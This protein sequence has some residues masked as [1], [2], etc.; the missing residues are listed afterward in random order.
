MRLKLLKFKNFKSFKNAEIYFTSNLN[1]IL[2]PNGS[3]KSNICDGLKFILGERSL[4][5]LRVKSSKEL[6]HGDSNYANVQAVFEYNGVQLILEREIH[7]DKNVYKIN[8]KR[9]TYEEYLTE[10]IKLNLGNSYRFFIMQGQ[11][12]KIIGLNKNEKMQLLYDGAGIQQFEI[13]KNEILDE[14]KVIDER[15]SQLSLLIGEKMKFLD[16]L[17]V[18]SERASMYMDVKN[19]IEILRNTLAYLEYTRISKNIDNAKTKLQELSNAKTELEQKLEQIRA[20]I[21]QVNKEREALLDELRSKE[22]SKILID[23]T[24]QQESLQK[25]RAELMD[26]QRLLFERNK[27]YQNMLNKRQETID[28]IGW[29]R[30]KIKDV[31]VGDIQ[32]NLDKLKVVNEELIEI[33]AELSNLNVKYRE[34]GDMLKNIDITQLKSELARLNNEI[35]EVYKQDRELSDKIKAIDEEIRRLEK[36][37]ELNQIQSNILILENFIKDLKSRVDGIHDMVI[38]LIS[39]DSKL[40]NAVD[41]FGT[42]LLNI[43]VD[44]VDNAKTINEILKSSSLRLGRISIIPLKQLNVP[45]YRNV[46]VGLG[47]LKNHIRTEQRFEKVLD[48]VFGDVVLMKGFD[49][50]RNYI[51]KYRMVTLD[52][53]MF[54]LTGVITIGSSNLSISSARLYSE[55]IKKI[56]ELKTKRDGLVESREKLAHRIAELRERKAALDSKLSVLSTN[57]STEDLSKIGNRIDQLNKRKEE[58]K[59]V[60]ETLE[61]EI[62]AYQDKLKDIEQVAAFKKELEIKGKEL[63][64]IE[65][66]IR[67]LDQEIKELNVQIRSMSDQ[68]RIEELGVA[69]KRRQYMEMDQKIREKMEESKYK[70][71]ELKTLGYEQQKISE[72]L[73]N[74]EKSYYRYE[75]ELSNLE[76]ELKNISYKEDVG[77]VEGSK[78]QIEQEVSQLE[79]TI[80]SFGNINFKAKEMY[81]ALSKDIGEIDQ[82]IERLRKE[83]ED[84]VNML[85]EVEAKKILFFKDFIKR[86]DD[87]FK[88]LTRSIAGLGEATIELVEGNIEISLF[89][90]NKKIRLESLSGGEKS[91]L[92]LLLIFAMNHENPLPITVFDEVDA[93]LDKMNKERLKNFILSNSEKTQFIIVTHNQDLAKVGQNIIGVSK[94][95]N[96]S[97]IAQISI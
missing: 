40:K 59:S 88:E 61:K 18:E 75:R 9:V 2:G 81:D 46:N 6:I 51:G 29:L 68:I 34:F 74:V 67:D 85:N 45:S 76:I 36:E 21:E 42:R 80:S 20:Q 37:K 28:R 41:A 22:M 71:E 7:E 8:S 97:R 31:D 52:G 5:N 79:A 1:V 55:I 19:K 25:R 57:I 10:L 84:L 23:L 91:L 44:D 56:D 39:F 60:K 89:R 73:A 90:D 12:E 65:N 62:S 27:M 15:I 93:A 92:G 82:R 32:N 38:N 35:L 30:A 43:V 48:Y 4:A 11:V 64:E 17:K 33:E 53:E 94:V 26:R 96:S 58:L 63:E 50:A 16:E 66:N 24:E 14:M 13:R 72:Q 69:Q 70:E 83:R 78:E 54:E 3:G 86:V 77:I 87:R 95:G 49:E 47:L